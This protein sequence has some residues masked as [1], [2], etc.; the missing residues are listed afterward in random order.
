LDRRRGDPS[1]TLYASLGWRLTGI[2][3]ADA[4]SAG[5]RLDPSAFYHKL[6]EGGT[7]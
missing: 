6:L 4:E 7:T 1:E 2:V 3:P 5:R